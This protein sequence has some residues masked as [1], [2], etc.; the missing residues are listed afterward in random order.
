[1]VLSLTMIHASF[2]SWLSRQVLSVEIRLSHGIAR[3]ALQGPTHRTLWCIKM[4]YLAGNLPLGF[5][6]PI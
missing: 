3:K 4:V 1:M 5:Q 2:L 6:F